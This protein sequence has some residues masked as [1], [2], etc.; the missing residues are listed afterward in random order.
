MLWAVSKTVK[1][2]SISRCTWFFSKSSGSWCSS[3]AA[4][5]CRQALKHLNT[6]PG[7]HWLPIV[8]MRELG[9]YQNMKEFLKTWSILNLL[10]SDQTDRHR[11][12]KILRKWKL[13]LLQRNKHVKMRG[14]FTKSK[15]KR[16]FS[17]VGWQWKW[18]VWEDS[19]TLMLYIL[20]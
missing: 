18:E 9:R 16:L 8:M 13:Q 2:I 20:H 19:V 15:K 17:F 5:V 12:I 6:H 14:L 11:Y 10:T 3:C 4:H 1:W 7:E